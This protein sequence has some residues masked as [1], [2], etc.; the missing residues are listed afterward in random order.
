MSLRTLIKQTRP[1]PSPP[2]PTTPE[3]VGGGGNTPLPPQPTVR[4]NVPDRFNIYI[5]R[6]LDHEGG[7]VNHPHDPGGETK[8]G[9]TK[10]T[11]PHLDIRNLTRE[12]AIEI[13]RK[14]FWER[15]GVAKFPAELGFQVLDAAINHG[16]GNAIRWVQRAVGVADD[17]VAG[18]LTHAAA[19]RIPP[20]DLVLLFNAER[21]RFYT[22]LN[23]FPTFG[24]GWVRRVADNL[25]HAA[26]DN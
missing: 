24:R 20:T 13:Y 7:Y 5:N 23:T 9:I 4:T 1:L 15:Y 22:K 6:V 8:Y 21:L 12:Q 11:Y 14:D 17:G 19:W 2:R 25:E 26:E 10:R 18:P 3:R 16:G